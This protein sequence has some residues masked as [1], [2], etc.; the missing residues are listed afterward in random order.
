MKGFCCV[1][2]WDRTVIPNGAQP[3][4]PGARQ[5]FRSFC[6]DERIC[7]VYASG[8]DLK[9]VQQAIIDYELP[10]PDYAIT[11]VGSMIYQ[12]SGNDWLAIHEWQE[13]IA[14]DWHGYGH[15]DLASALA[16]VAALEIQEPDKQNRF[17]L[18]YYLDLET[19]SE[20][21]LARINS[22]L[23]DLGVAA[24]LIWSVDEA[25]PVGLIDI[26]PQRADKLNALNFLYRYLNYA[27]TELLFA[28]DSGNDLTVLESHIP[29]V[30][31]ANGHPDVRTSALERAARNGFAERLY[32]AG[33]EDW[34]G[35][36]NYCSGVLQGVVYF[37]PQLRE[38][39]QRIVT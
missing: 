29:A 14:R 15:A 1:P 26:L 18:S 30:L 31:V 35:N 3:E 10:P 27:A 25:V 5:W 37:Y 17:K 11:D 7:L 28:G 13:W 8:R 6:D 19:S 2:I 16:P 38:S 4:T 21:V 22:I 32:L 24:N 9:L 12:A 20:Q 23:T 39:I 33:P 34:P 36:G